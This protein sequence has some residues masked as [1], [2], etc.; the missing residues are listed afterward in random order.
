MKNENSSA[1]ILEPKITAIA[2]W[3]GGKRTLAP[4]IVEQLGEHLQYFEPFCGSMAVLFAKKPS[5]HETVNDLHGDLINLARCLQ[6]EEIAIRL[7]ERLQRTLVC[8]QLLKDAQSVIDG[9]RLF[10]LDSPDSERAYWYFIASWMARNGI[11]GMDRIQYQIAVRW[12]PGGG[13][14]T[15]RWRSATD[16]VPWWHNRLKDAVILNRDAFDMLDRFDDKEHTAIYLDPPYYGGS[17]SHGNYKHDFEHDSLFGSDH[18]RLAEAVK[19]YKHARVVVSYYDCP[20]VRQLYE[21]WTFID[22]SM[23][24]NLH[25]QN[26]RG[27]RQQQ[28]P[29]VLIVN[30]DAYGS[31]LP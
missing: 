23:N 31:A 7:Y 13:S 5:R 17:R 15:T 10:S 4:R 18:Q 2:P 6:Q 9:D 28:A 1:S 21:G 26:G 25:A 30:G 24:K 16:S 3:F 12:T 22:C 27:P 19:A 8:E 14:P 20:A 11:A 29:E